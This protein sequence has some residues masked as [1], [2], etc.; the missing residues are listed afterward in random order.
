MPQE[1]IL[2]KIDQ[3]I[4]FTFIYDLVKGLYQEAEWGKSGIDP[5]SLFKIV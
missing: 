1:H 5:M 3:S 4:D 2:R